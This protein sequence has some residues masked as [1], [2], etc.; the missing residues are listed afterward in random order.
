MIRA[1]A[2][3]N[4]SQAKN[5]F[6][7]SLQPTTSYY[8]ND[9]A[10]LN[11]QELRG[12]FYGRTAARLGIVGLADRDTFTNLCDNINPVTGERLTPRNKE[13]RLVAM[14]ISF[15]VPKSVSICSALSEDDHIIKAFQQSV[16]ET[17]LE[18]EQD[19]MTRVRSN[20][21]D[22]DR[23]TG[24]LIIAEFIHQTAR[25]V[26]GSV[27]DP[28]L[29]AHCLVQNISYCEE[30]KRYKAV[31]FREINRS[32]PYFQQRYHKRLADKLMELGYTIRQTKSAFE[33]E[34]VPAHVLD[35]FAKRSSQ[36]GEF[37]EKHKITDPKILDQLAAITRGKK[38][39]DMSMEELRADWRRQILDASKGKEA[40]N[41]VVI[42]QNAPVRSPQ[43]NLQKIVDHAAQHRF[44][45]VSTISDRR[46]LESAYRYAVGNNSV[47]LDEITDTFIQDES[48]IRVKEGYQ[49][50]CTKKEVLIEEREMVN[51]ARSGQGRFKPFYNVV[52]EIKL[53]G[54]QRNAVEHVLTTKDLVSIIRGAAGTGKTTTLKELDRHLKALGKEPVYV[55]P[56]TTA[57]RDVLIKEGFSNAETVAQLLANKDLQSKLTNEILIVDESSLIGCKDMRALLSVATKAQAKVVLLGD[58]KQHSS[59]SRGDSLRILID[60]AKIKPAEMNKIRRQR[61][62]KYRAAVQDLANGNMKAAFGK[63]ADIDAIRQIDPLNPNVD[64]VADYVSA[65]KR[66]KSALIV[67][68]THQQIKS[69]TED[70]RT[71]LKDAGLLG[72]NELKVLKLSGL[73]YTEA[74]KGDWR[75]FRPGQIIQFNQNVPK[76]KRGTLWTIKE[77]ANGHTEIVNQ[78]GDKRTLPLNKAKAFDVFEPSEID[79]A[80]GDKVRV[81]RNGFDKKSKRLNNGQAFDVVSVTKS[82]MKLRQPKGK[83]D[84][85]IKNDFGHIEHAYCTTS[86][87]SQGMTVDEVFISQPA[88]T[89]AATDSKTAYVSISRG[90]DFVTIYTDDK[91]QLLEY[92]ER[93]GDRLSAMELVAKSKLS[94]QYRSQPAR[95]RVI[96]EDIKQ[97]TVNT[98]TKT[99]RHLD[100]EP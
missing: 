74:E 21:K 7:D 6:T 15:H 42:R 85:I 75:N 90:R 11:A 65:V 68:P 53:D 3:F 18:M 64:L 98:P 55:A 57:V 8:F 16:R 59:I 60:V 20:G 97:K 19:A 92:A 51:L 34:G 36:I 56:T 100:Y 49:T 89:F 27:A 24:E 37:A 22:E 78:E 61:N 46:L 47:T 67:S 81:T 5:Y 77:S 58:V 44:E 35:L 66:K 70:V 95:A 14:D 17:M 39:K 79:I 71:E 76:I 72:K 41:D 54:Q 93:T 26:D 31:Q 50:I 43:L 28:H 45:R 4:S 23:Y 69:V 99:N 9:G 38:Q 82:E 40:E 94:H 62:D 2:T 88:A 12:E 73:N 29:H 33:I 10:L 13:N 30:E 25:P 96:T 80:K 32:L 63:L 1:K 87:S 52:P 48:F 86:H 83:T 84:F 91:E